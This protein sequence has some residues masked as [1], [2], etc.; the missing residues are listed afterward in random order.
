MRMNGGGVDPVVGY[1]LV[2]GAHA[3]LLEEIVEPKSF[4]V[5]IRRILSLED[6]EI[7]GIWWQAILSFVRL[8]LFLRSAQEE[9]TT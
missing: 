6:G 8:D 3:G 4:D 2:S 1:L 7:V 9:G 5:P